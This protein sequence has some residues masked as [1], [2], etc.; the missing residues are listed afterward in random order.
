M[1][2]VCVIEEEIYILIKGQ[3]FRNSSFKRIFDLKGHEFTYILV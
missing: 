3:F 1:W 2:A